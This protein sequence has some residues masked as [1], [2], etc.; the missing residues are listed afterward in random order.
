MA[1]APEKR[2]RPCDQCRSAVTWDY[3]QE[4]RLP[5]LRW[6]GCC[7][8]WMYEVD[9]NTGKLRYKRPSHSLMVQLGAR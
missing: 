9:Q 5:G 2:K 7:G 4:G 6:T 3:K 8:Y 1:I